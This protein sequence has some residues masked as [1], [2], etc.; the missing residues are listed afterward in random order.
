MSNK[1]MGANTMKIKVSDLSDIAL[2]WTVAKCTDKVVDILHELSKGDG[3]RLILGKGCGT[4]YSP[5]SDWSQGGPIIERE[6]ISTQK[7][8]SGW[9]ASYEDIYNL[10]IYGQTPLIAAMRCYVA[11]KLG[12]EVEVPDELIGD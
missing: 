1:Q 9:M 5:S 11:S 10:P 2:D 6:G 8:I 7:L 3:L 4:P 12:E